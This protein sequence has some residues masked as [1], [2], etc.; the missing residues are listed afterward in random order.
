MHRRVSF[1]GQ[2]LE[3]EDIADYHSD[4]ETIPGT[5]PMVGDS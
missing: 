5:F 4:A 1:S 2:H 3:L